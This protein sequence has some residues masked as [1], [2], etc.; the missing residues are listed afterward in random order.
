[1]IGLHEAAAAIGARAEGAEVLLTGVSTDSRTLAPGDLFVAIRGPRHD[2][3]AFIGAAAARGAV[4]TMVDERYRAAL[5]PGA[6]APLPLLV[7]DDTRHALG[8]FAA[9][10]RERFAPQVVAVAGSNGK[11][12]TKEMLAAILRAHAGARAVLATAGNLN[13]DLGVALTLLRLRDAHRYCAVEIGMNHP[14]EVAPLARMVRPQIAVVTNAQREHMEFMKSVEACAAEN[15]AVYEALPAD[16]VAVVN[17]DDSHAD[18][19]L[20][21]AGGRQTVRFGLEAGA[22]VSGRCIPA[23]LDTELALRTPAG[24]ATVRLA[25]AGVHS[26]RNALAAAACAFAAGVPLEAIVRGLAAFR[27]VAGRLAAERLA[28]G[29]IVV[30]DSYNANPDSVRAAIDVL[31]A[32]PAP[33]VLVLGDMGEVGEFASEFH[34]E[35]GEYARRRGISR[36]AAI[37]PAARAAVE[38]FGAGAA[39]FDDIE[40]LAR[41]A[42]GAASVLVKGSRFMRMERVV[43]LL[44][45]AWAPCAEAH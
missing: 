27:P 36:L 29:A 9:R 43:A 30:D 44:R 26:A 13:T 31:A 20:R 35:V 32:L 41:A 14:G 12:T 10:W 15:A 19:F 21:A 22:E 38:A 34:R 8:R 7:V 39:H 17:A 45:G 18:L 42:E 40:A 16:G 2:G 37:G 1:M 28:C 33:T 24:E 11:T 3:H 6:R 5:G 25:I 4:A 23:G